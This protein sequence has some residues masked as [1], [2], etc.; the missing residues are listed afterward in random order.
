VGENEFAGYRFHKTDHQRL[1]GN[2]AFMCATF[3]VQGVVGAIR[4]IAGIT[5]QQTGKNDG[6]LAFG[7]LYPAKEADV[8]GWIEDRGYSEAKARRLFQSVLRTGTV[9]VSKAGVVSVSNWLSE[10]EDPSTANT[11][12]KR[13]SV[14]RKRAEKVKEIIGP[15]SGE[16]LP[17]GHLVGFVVSGTGWRRKTVSRLIDQLVAA[18]VLR[19]TESGDIQVSQIAIK[20]NGGNSAPPSLP[21]PTDNNNAATDNPDMSGKKPDMSGRLRVE[22]KKET[23]VS[24]TTDNLPTGGRDGGA[25]FNRILFEDPVRAAQ[26]VTKGFGDVDKRIFGAKL[27]D[28]NAKFTGH[29]KHMFCMA[30]ETLNAEVKAG[31]HAK[32]I[33]RNQLAQF[34]T[35]RMKKALTE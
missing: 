15:L 24:L 11:K 3:E 2:M 28:Y 7:A 4:I 14:D 18:D 5:R 25:E 10:Q 21:P 35:G 17:E 33:A 19:R 23:N 9:T 34:L 26:I 31:E 16:S 8:L 30:V 1:S 22:S 20:A 27:R 12:H 13:D 32:I 6:R 29:G